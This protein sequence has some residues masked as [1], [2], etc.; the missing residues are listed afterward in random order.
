MKTWQA[1]AAL[2]LSVV[3]FLSYPLF[4][5]RWPLT[6]DVPWAN[7][8][9]FAATLALAAWRRHEPGH[10]A[11]PAFILAGTTL[12]S[13][14]VYMAAQDWLWSFFTSEYTGG[15]YLIMVGVTTT[16][17]VDITCNRSRVSSIIAR[18]FWYWPV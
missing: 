2:P 6:R 13:I 9:L 16:L 7:F 12:A 14:L 15:W 3:A 5:L 17:L 18:A 1:W 11:L 10:V 4:F 8:A